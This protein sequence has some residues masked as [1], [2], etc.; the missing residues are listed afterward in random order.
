MIASPAVPWS[1]R[2]RDTDLERC[3][4]LRGQVRSLLLAQYDAGGRLYFFEPTRRVVVVLGVNRPDEAF[5]KS[6]SAIVRIAS[7]SGRGAVHKV[8]RINFNRDFTPRATMSNARPRSERHADRVIFRDPDGKEWRHSYVK[9]LSDDEL[10]LLRKQR[11]EVY[12]RFEEEESERMGP[13]G[14][15]GALWDDE[16]QDPG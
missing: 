5:S 10:M 14:K 12:R 2:W 4:V 8:V 7:V 3:Q 13:P 1:I 9:G 15:P 16:F 11:P 6:L